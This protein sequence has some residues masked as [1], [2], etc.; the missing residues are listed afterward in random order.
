MQFDDAVLAARK[1]AA[2]GK[3][4]ELEAIVAAI[5]SRLVE[6]E[7]EL[8]MLKRECN[9]R[10][11]GVLVLAENVQNQLSALR[12]RVGKMGELMDSNERQIFH[13]KRC[14]PPKKTNARSA[15]PRA[16]EQAKLQP[17]EEPECPK[18]EG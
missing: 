12:G 6:V 13:L 17:E 8:A 3:G 9:I 4:I 1:L 18:T 16:G 5:A 10:Q 15:S 14:I 7:V 2:K 11:D